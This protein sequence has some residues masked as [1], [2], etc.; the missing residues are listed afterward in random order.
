MHKK[1][2]LVTGAA[3]EL[4]KDEELA[5]KQIGVMLAQENYKLIVGDW[6]GVDRIVMNSFLECI[7]P[8]DQAARIKHIENYED[9]GIDKKRIKGAE[10]IEDDGDDP[11]YSI[12]A[13]RSADAGIIISGRE[14]SKPSM[15]ALI[16]LKKPILPVAFLGYDSFEVYRDIL[17]HWNEQ[18]VTGLNQRQFLELMK[19]WKYNPEIISRMLRAA[20]SKETEI[21]IS[22]RRTD[23]AAV[24]GRLYEELAHTYGYNATFIDY[25]NLNA[26]EHLE[27]ILSRVKK[28]KILISIIGKDWSCDRLNEKEDYV[29]RELEIAQQ[30]E[31]TVI[32]LLV[33][34]STL[35]D[36]N[37]LPSS[38]HFILA[39]NFAKVNMD[40]WNWSVDQIKRNIDGLLVRGG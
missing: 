6:V 9:I 29:R 17:T 27:A 20:L 7:P 4:S 3:Y 36:K 28:S 16:R 11:N 31:V 25:E 19:P 26:G 37:H 12:S 1:W 24:A 40:D 22:Y 30:N 15:E 18:P 14:G 38:L 23:T 2:I 39:L 34:I 13:I 32:P 35:P 5:S 33:D 8:N 21:F 10:V